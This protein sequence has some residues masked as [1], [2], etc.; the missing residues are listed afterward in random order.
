MESE[1]GKALNKARIDRQVKRQLDFE[2]QQALLA[3]NRADAKR[4]LSV[5]WKIC[6]N[7]IALGAIWAFYLQGNHPLAISAGVYVLLSFLTGIW[8]KSKGLPFLKC[9][10]MALLI[11]PL[12]AWFSISTWLKKNSK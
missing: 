7:I 2:E 3:Q 8:A 4:W 12:L 10:C 6:L 9:Q 1:Y 11:T 5:W